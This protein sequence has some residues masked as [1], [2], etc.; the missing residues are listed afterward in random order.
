MATLIPVFSFV[1]ISYALTSERRIREPEEKI[2]NWHP[3]YTR[4]AMPSNPG[5]R[6]RGKSNE[7]AEAKVRYFLKQLVALDLED[8]A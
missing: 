7:P 8:D 5:S 2:S 4:P 3:P 6:K 1:M